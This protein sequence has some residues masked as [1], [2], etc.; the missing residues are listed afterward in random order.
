MGV[1][2]EVEEVGPGRLSQAGE[3]VVVLPLADVDHALQHSTSIALGE[4]RRPGAGSEEVPG[5]VA[6]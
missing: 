6:G 1:A 5:T 4:R 2:V 3:H